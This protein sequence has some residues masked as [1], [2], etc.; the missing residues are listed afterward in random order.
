[1]ALGLAFAVPANAFT[2]SSDAS[3]YAGDQE[4][5]I[6]VYYQGAGQ[7]VTSVKANIAYDSSVLYIT[8][9]ETAGSAFPHWWEKAITRGASG[10]IRLQASAPASQQS[11]LVATVYARPLKAG[12]ATLTLQGNSL[13][14]TMQDQNVL[15]TEN[16]EGLTLTITGTSFFVPHTFPG[17]LRLGDENADVRNFQRFLNMHGYQAAS[18]GPGSP[19]NET[20][21][22]GPRTE[23]AAIRFQ[24]ANAQ[25]ILAPLGLARGT[26]YVGPSTRNFINDFIQGRTSTA[27]SLVERP[28]VSVA[29]SPGAPS[30]S[31]F[32]RDLQEG[33]V[34]PEVRALQQY[35]NANGFPVAQAGAGSPGQETEYF[36]PRTRE[37][38]IRFQNANAQQILLPL[39]LIT[40]TGYFGQST[41]AFISQGL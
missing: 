33:S 11:G 9:V 32:L 22:F 15:A 13:A 23:R 35:F 5:A 20:E 29:V 39:G 14:L 38:L 18:T 2:L 27:L 41:R 34:G 31:A 26:G 21:Y 40:G 4:I 3:S 16:L 19:G 25:A 6:Q 30:S 10:E 17:D 8:R 24:E 7:P 36:G 1:M 12:A 28:A 37:A